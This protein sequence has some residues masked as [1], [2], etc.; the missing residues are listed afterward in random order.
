LSEKGVSRLGLEEDLSSF[1]EEVKGYIQ[2]LGLVVYP[3]IVMTDLQTVNFVW[4]SNIDPDWRAFVNA[5]KSMGVG[6]VL[7]GRERERRGN[8]E[9]VGLVRMVW[10]KDGVIHI[11][12]KGTEWYGLEEPELPEYLR[13]PIETQ[14]NEAT[15]YLVKEYGIGNLPVGYIWRYWETKSIPDFG[16]VPEANVTIQKVNQGVERSI[17]ELEKPLLEELVKDCVAWARQ[18]RLKK[19]KKGEVKTFLAERDKQ[20]S[21]VSED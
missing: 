10:P 16:E 11:F 1:Y 6:Y 20:L 18:N 2:S 21:Q 3:G 5:A 7:V 15:E 4:D 17:R 9:K 13:R 19:V 12:E 14:V 8:S